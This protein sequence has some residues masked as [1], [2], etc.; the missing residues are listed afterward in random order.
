MFEDAQHFLCIKKLAD[1]YS[2]QETPR[3]VK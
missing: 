3:F 1:E 2:N